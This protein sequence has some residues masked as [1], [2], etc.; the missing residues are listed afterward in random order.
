MSARAEPA[1]SERPSES[2]ASLF[3]A[4]TR[5]QPQQRSRPLALGE[6]CRAEVVQVGR[7]AVFLEILDRNAG[8]K[9]P[10]ALMNLIDLHAPD[11]TVTVKA[12][13][14]LEGVVVEL[15]GRSGEIRLG[16]SMGKPAGADEVATAH[17]AGVPVEGKVSGVNKGGLEVEVA[18]IRAFCP[19]SQ[20]DRGF[21]ADPQALVG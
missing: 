8:G 1:M 21:T 12:G 3:E 7:D 4:E 16:R 17:A 19:V 2:F 15:D 11:G 6:R 10:Q 18:G 14:V 13:D 9:R 20:I 5:D